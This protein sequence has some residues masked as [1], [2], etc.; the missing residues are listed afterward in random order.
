METDTIRTSVT[1]DLLN[2]AK[3]HDKEALT[4]L[5]NLSSQ[6]VYR[7][8]RGMVRDEDLAL[9]IQQNTY[10]KAFSHL[11][12]LRDAA[13][14]IPWIRR[15]A[16]NEAKLELRKNKAVLFSDLHSDEDDAAEPE[17]PDSSPE[18]SPELALDRKETAR[19]MHEILDGLPDGQRMVVSMYYYEQIP[20]KDIAKMLDV[21]EGA[22]KT[23]LHCGRKKIESAVRKLE[24]RGVKLLGMSPVSYLVA[25]MSRVELVPAVQEKVLPVVMA[26]TATDAVGVSTVAVHAARPLLQRVGGR[27]AAIALVFLLSG[28]V[29]YGVSRSVRT[30]RRPTDDPVM[31]VSERPR[32]ATGEE[33]RPVGSDET[34]SETVPSENTE[35]TTTPSSLES[36]TPSAPTEAPTESTEPPTESPS[37][38]P[39][40]PSAPTEA[41]T[42]PPA[43]E[44]EPEAPTE[45]E[46][47]PY[48]IGPP[49]PSAPTEAPTEPPATEQEPEEPTESESEPYPIGPPAP[50]ESTTEPPA[51]EQEPEPPT[52]S[53]SE[54]DPIGPP[55]PS[56]STTEPPAETETENPDILDSGACGDDVRW[57][58][59]EDGALSITGSG[60]M[61]DYCWYGEE[62]APWK[63]Y[64]STIQRVTISD[65]VT[66][67]SDAAF[68]ECRR[69]TSVTIPNSV[70]E[71][72]ADAFINCS[73]LK[74][75]YI[76]DL[77]AWCRIQFGDMYS[78]PLHYAYKLTVNGT[79][80]R[81]LTIPNGITSI[82]NYAFCY[83]GSLTSVTIPNSVTSIGKEA[84]SACKCLTSVTI[85][86]SVTSIGDS[87]FALCY[88][89]KTVTIENGVTFINDSAFYNCSSLTSVTIPDSVTSIGDYAFGIGENDQPISGF[90][91]RGVPGTAA[92][93]YAERYGLTFQ[94]VSQ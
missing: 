25:L 60:P 68:S 44:Q 45:S 66:K 49:A 64:A 13:V 61:D 89:L 51:T 26:H 18:G 90:L 52:E 58:L 28:G 38:E 71:I 63:A 2:R 87:A 94:A 67:I 53:E 79:E 5:Y 37:T 10:L 69:M 8:V 27:V 48:P 82:G 6:A 4:Q 57:T 83:C 62:S 14:F 3:A 29:I 75:V 55:A 22:V 21:S 59:S 23:Q 1:Q 33:T 36:T 70:T 92:E 32:P 47:E 40:V 42:E 84:F 86:G 16:V 34:A 12:Q 72:G 88:D 20:I 30:N 9:D 11:D 85:P 77:A 93:T 15:I 81:S 31:I 35:S 80:L 91:V 7:S 56:E 43:T 73:G 39:P 19:Q 74:S 46:S 76:S 54:P 78:N 50:S 17:L 41:P 24:K 65:G